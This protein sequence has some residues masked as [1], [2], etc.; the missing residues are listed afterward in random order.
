MEPKGPGLRDRGNAS[1]FTRSSTNGPFVPRPTPVIVFLSSAITIC[2]SCRLAPRRNR[3]KKRQD[4]PSL[5]L[6]RPRVR[7]ASSPEESMQEVSRI[8]PV[9]RTT[10]LQMAQNASP[11]VG[12]TEAIPIH[13][14]V[15]SLREQAGNAAD[16]NPIAAQSAKAA[17][18]R[19]RFIY[20]LP[21][22]AY[23]GAFTRE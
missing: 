1:T 22:C 23:A 12:N 14:P 19:A 20:P 2:I 11:P 4:G 6:I 18:R 5:R 17:R 16:G 10:N 7:G 21:H 9:G 8:L 13:F 15:A 3:A